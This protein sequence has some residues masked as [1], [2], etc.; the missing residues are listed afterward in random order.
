MTTD[1]RRAQERALLL[2]TISLLI[3]LFLFVLPARYLGVADLSWSMWLAAV[4]LTLAVQG[5]LWW[6]L[7]RGWSFVER[8]DPYFLHFPVLGASLLLNVFFYAAPDSRTLGLF[9]WLLVL[10][11]GCGRAGFAEVMGWTF[12]QLA[13]YLTVLSILRE[14]I[15]GWSSSRELVQLWMF[16]GVCFG[17]GVLLERLKRWL[18]RAK[19]ERRRSEATLRDSEERLRQVIDLVPHFIFA[20]DWQGRYVLANRA[21]AEAFGTTPDR[22]LRHSD[23]ELV[24]SAQEREQFRAAERDVLASGEPR[25]SVDERL[26]DARGRQRILQTHRIP[27]TFRSSE[28]PAILGVAIDVTEVRRA[29]EQQR[30]LEAQVQQL[31]KLE[32]LGALA[33]GV[34]HDFNN[35]L[36]GVLGNAELALDDLPEDSPGRRRLERVVTSAQ[37]AAELVNQLLAYSGQGQF[38]IEKL[39]LSQLAERLRDLISASISKKAVLTVEATHGPVW[40]DADPAQLHQVLINLITNAS[41]ALEEQAGSI[42]LATGRTR[43]GNRDLDGD[44]RAE[45]FEPGDVAFIE[46]ADDGSGMDAETR[47]RI[48]DPFFTTKFV[49]RGLGLAAVLGI[50]LGHRGAIRIDSRPGEGT[51]IRVLL[52]LAAPP[53]RPVAPAAGRAGEP[54]DL[55]PGTFLVVDDDPAVREFVTEALERSG[56]TVLLA[57]DGA[58]GVDV[59]RRRAD[60]IDLVLLDVMMPVMNGAETFHELRLIH[61][62]VRVVLMSGF[63]EQLA[64]NGLAENGPDGFLQKP[65][66][67][68]ELTRMIRDVLAGERT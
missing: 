14:R 45:D 52:P 46:V 25:A 7:R 20:K 15:A 34:A 66:S 38:L 36:V 44:I 37:R 47:D 53:A 32:S 21:V 31:Q 29:E 55:P 13:G 68:E 40:V 9:A 39:D 4:A 61:P 57:S 3:Y 49:G 56:G 1:K 33:G 2:G 62:E 27:F 30:Q 51:A 42:R 24:G 17:I 48:F 23:A 10:L 26:T 12:V 5:L 63:S 59:Y 60:E 28:R 19:A 58:E 6:I 16:L 43:V 35:I 64:T 41:D 50:V 11:F 54:A 67:P 18:E 22:L 8:H 65:Y